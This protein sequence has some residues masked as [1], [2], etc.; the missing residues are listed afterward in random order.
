LN[1]QQGPKGNGIINVIPYFSNPKIVPV[2]SSLAASRSNLFIKYLPLTINEE[3][4]S[5]LF[6]KF[7]AIKSIRVKRPDP[8]RM[9]SFGSAPYAIAYLEF[10]REED[11]ATALAQTNGFYFQGNNISVEHY[12]KS[13]QTQHHVTV[14]QQDVIGDVYLKGLHIKGLPKSVIIK[15]LIIY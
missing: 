11:A 6:A 1:G 10:Q 5:I 13:K 12:D 7:G 8:S 15:A 3:Q 9:A 14:T 2:Q 4:L